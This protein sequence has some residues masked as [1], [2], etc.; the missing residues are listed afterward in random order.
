VSTNTFGWYF[1]SVF[2]FCS[3]FNH[4][5]WSNATHVFLF[6]IF[7]LSDG[8]STCLAVRPLNV[9]AQLDKGIVVFLKISF[10]LSVFSG[11]F[12]FGALLARTAAARYFSLS[13]SEESRIVCPCRSFI[14]RHVSHVR[15]WLKCSDLPRNAFLRINAIFSVFLNP[16]RV[17]AHHSTFPLFLSLIHVSFSLCFY[18][19]LWYGQSSDLFWFFRRLGRV[20]LTWFIIFIHSWYNP[21]N[22][23]VTYTIYFSTRLLRLWNLCRTS[24]TTTSSNWLGR[25]HL[26]R[27]MSPHQ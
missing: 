7:V 13:R 4:Q 15:R 8:I 1:F 18:A 23:D 14:S 5:L 10:C 6:S 2:I 11:F 21:R 26:E 12:L 24:S 16:N 19:S 20:F 3:V 22:K 9:D 17:G 27:C 25:W